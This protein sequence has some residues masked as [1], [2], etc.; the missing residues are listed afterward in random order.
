LES[1]HW[2]SLFPLIHVYNI[3]FRMWTRCLNIAR[4]CCYFLNRSNVLILTNS[5][6]S[7][8]VTNGN[9][10]FV[11][12]D[13]HECK[14]TL[15]KPRH[16]SHA[17]TSLV[18]EEPPK[19]K[20]KQFKRVSGK[21]TWSSNYCWEWHTWYWFLSVN[22]ITYQCYWCKLCLAIKLVKI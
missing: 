8:F 18:V 19:K 10:A 16:L 1:D 5:L 11:F 20:Y 3:T 9:Q 12:W 17:S 21:E 6:Q 2:A 4:V 22:V 7:R 14:K 15:Q 13:G